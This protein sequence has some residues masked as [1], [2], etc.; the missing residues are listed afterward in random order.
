MVSKVTW[1]QRGPYLQVPR[2]RGLLEEV[3]QGQWAP[4]TELDSSHSTCFGVI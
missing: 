3:L 2:S 1:T 4:G